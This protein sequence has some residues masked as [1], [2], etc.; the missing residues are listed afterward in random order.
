MERLSNFALAHVYRVTCL[1]AIRGR[2]LAKI[3]Y[4]INCTFL[5]PAFTVVYYR[6]HTGVWIP[7]GTDAIWYPRHTAQIVYDIKPLMW[8]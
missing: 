8:N 6:L 1:D 4:A 5:T 2:K 3:V 7:Y